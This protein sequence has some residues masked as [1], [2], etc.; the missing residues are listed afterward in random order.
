MGTEI[1]TSR[2]DY[3]YDSYSYFE[4]SYSYSGSSSSSSDG[5]GYAYGN[6]TEEINA[7]DAAREQEREQWLQKRREGFQAKRDALPPHVPSFRE[8]VADRFSGF[9]DALYEALPLL[10][11]IFFITVYVIG[12]LQQ[13]G[14]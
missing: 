12:D 5:C 9:G 6:T 11:F 3:A 7:A 8:R 4:P 1:R 2:N 10:G 14:Y 13:Q